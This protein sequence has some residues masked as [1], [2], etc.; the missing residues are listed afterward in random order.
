MRGVRRYRAV[1]TSGRDLAVRALRQP[2]ADLGWRPRAAGWATTPIA[3]QRTGV[4]AVSAASEHA[5]PGTAHVTLHVHLRCDDVQPVV[6]MLT[7]DEVPDGGYRSTTAVTSIGYL[8]PDPAW[9]TW[10]VTSSTAAEVAAELA[11]AVRDHARPWLDRLAADPALLLAAVERSP[12][13]ATAAGPCTLAVLLAG[14]G[15]A[16]AGWAVMAERLAGLGGRTDPAAEDLR[17]TADRLRRW[18]EEMSASGG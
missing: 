7:G 2:L 16:E 5:A 18:L 12:A 6:R 1:V 11:V 8:M 9:R 14:A 13:M 10:P 17:R 4:L 3:A 15:R